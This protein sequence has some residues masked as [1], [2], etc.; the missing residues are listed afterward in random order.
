MQSAYRMLKDGRCA[1]AEA[2]VRARN[3]TGNAYWYTCLADCIASLRALAKP[4]DEQVRAAMTVLDSGLKRV[5]GSARIRLK[6]AMI[7]ANAG[8]IELAKE[9]AQEAVRTAKEKPETNSGG[10]ITKDDRLV[11]EEGEFFLT[12][13][14]PKGR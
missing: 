9:L 7:Q 2:F 3:D 6:M 8:N 10:G 14:E 13:L 1:E 12:A 5:R 11:V 4:T